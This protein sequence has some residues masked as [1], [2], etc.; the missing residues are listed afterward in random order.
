MIT[1]P[2]EMNIEDFKYFVIVKNMMVAGIYA[3]DEDNVYGTHL[4]GNAGK[5]G[6]VISCPKDALV[7]QVEAGLTYIVAN[8]EEA[9]AEDITNTISENV[10]EFIKGK[11]EE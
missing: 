5:K 10:L 4:K 9:M 3:E 6:T 7:Q 8:H 1:P 11:K 2:K